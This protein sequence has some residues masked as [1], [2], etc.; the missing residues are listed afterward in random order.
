MK[1]INSIFLKILDTLINLINKNK[2]LY[3]YL[4]YKHY[5]SN[6]DHLSSTIAYI[7]NKKSNNIIIIDIGAANGD[8]PIIFAKAFPDAKIIAYEPIPYSFEIAKEKCKNYKNINIKKIALSDKK[9]EQELYITSNYVSS[10]L[11]QLDKNTYD[12][13]TSKEEITVQT[14]TL[15]NE[16]NEYSTIDLIKIDVQGAEKIVLEN[17]I[18]TL[19]KTK[20]VLIE[21]SVSNQYQGGCLYFQIDKLMREHNFKLVGLFNKQPGFI[22]YDAPH[23]NKNQL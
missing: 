16:I 21:M 17:G 7:K 8:S 20:L 12:S 18:E 13:V 23:E 2:S 15:D 3:L 6:N 22:E 5:T 9:G 1:I 19:Q 4:K 11:F 10:S 14:D